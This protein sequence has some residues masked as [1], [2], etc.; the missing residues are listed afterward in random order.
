[1]ISVLLC[2]VYSTFLQD[3]ETVGLLQT[4]TAMTMTTTTTPLYHLA[5]DGKSFALVMQHHQ[6]LL[7]RV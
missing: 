5:I 4:T 2:Y 6:V 3:E 7:D 1:M